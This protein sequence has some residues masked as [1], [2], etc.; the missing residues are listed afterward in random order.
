[1]RISELSKSNN[2]D[3]NINHGMLHLLDDA[4][5]NSNS[6][7]NYDVSGLSLR[8][9]IIGELYMYVRWKGFKKHYV[10]MEFLRNSSNHISPQLKIYKNCTTAEPC[11][12]IILREYEEPVVDFR[13]QVRNTLKIR[14]SI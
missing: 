3:A 2:S 7:F 12:V 5:T 4:L 13:S 9:P 11:R 1:M 8:T 14:I 10:V 6:S